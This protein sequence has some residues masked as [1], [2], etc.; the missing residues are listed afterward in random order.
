[1]KNWVEVW[2]EWR[3]RHPRESAKTVF[4]AGYSMGQ[5]ST[6]EDREALQAK[7]TKLESDIQWLV[8]RAADQKLD[9]YRAL[10]ARAAAAE[11]RADEL[12]KKYADMCALVQGQ[13]TCTPDERD[14]LD[15]CALAEVFKGDGEDACI[16]RGEW[17]IAGAILRKRLNSK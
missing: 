8:A 9:G 15:A 12:Q 10:G 13:L 5:E 11:N 17:R 6:H 7:V 2:E 16:Q 3:S 14:I 1:M 4:G